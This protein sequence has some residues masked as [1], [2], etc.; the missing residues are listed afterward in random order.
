M[1]RLKVRIYIIV[2]TLFIVLISLILIIRS[3]MIDCIMSWEDKVYPGVS[4]CGVDMEGCSEEQIIEKINE[5]FLPKLRDKK[6]SILIND[7]E[8]I[9]DYS[10]LDATYDVKTSANE[11]LNYGKDYSVIYKYMIIK[12]NK[13]DIDIGLDFKYDNEKLKVIEDDVERKV[14]MEPKNATIEIEGQNINVTSDEVGYKVNKKN[15]DLLIK[16]NINGALKEDTRI[17]IGLDEVQAKIKE[18]DLRKI[19]GIMSTFESDYSFSKEERCKNI[20]LATSLVNGTILMPGEEFSYSE[21]TQRGRGHYESAAGYISNQVVQVEGGGICQVCTALYRAVMRS[22]I[23]ATERHGHSLPVSYTS[24]GLDATVAWGSLDYRFVNT[25]DFPIYIVGTTYN[26]CIQFL[27][28]G[29]PEAKEGNS[30]ELITEN[31]GNKV[32]AYLATYKDGSIIK[33]ELVSSDKIKKH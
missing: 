17:K 22:N 4:I 15:L 20:E 18:E 11:A 28:Y 29:D 31:K 12:G 16:D 30:Y 9:Y 26:K 2:T 21:T 14:E 25:Y 27:I 10:E 6:I 1:S 23:K 5:L 32:N 3:Y 19:K 24:I 13:V 33:K 7:N 8:Y